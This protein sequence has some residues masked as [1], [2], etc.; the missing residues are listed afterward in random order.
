[1]ST[2]IPNLNLESVEKIL[3]TL[4]SN[5]SSFLLFPFLDVEIRR[6][7]YSFVDSS[8]DLGN[9]S[10]VCKETNQN[11]KIAL[12]DAE[13]R[14]FSNLL[15]K[16]LVGMRSSSKALDDEYKSFKICTLDASDVLNTFEAGGGYWIYDYENM[17]FVKDSPYNLMFTNIIYWR[18]TFY[19]LKN[20]ALKLP[21][22]DDVVSDESIPGTYF[23]WDE[24]LGGIVAIGKKT[25][26]ALYDFMKT[27]EFEDEESEDESQPSSED[28]AC[29]EV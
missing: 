20:L 13:Q 11:T 18:K 3:P 4:E 14:T 10:L 6:Y 5:R 22:E 25:G 21:Y 19:K 1:M 2:I 8:R 15:K 16:K 28:D 17:L 27:F 7:I 23:S 26:R 9:L 24:Q 12:E 29:D